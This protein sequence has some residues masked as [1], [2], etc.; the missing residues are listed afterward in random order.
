M[1]GDKEEF[2]MLP[3]SRAPESWIGRATGTAY[4]DRAGVLYV[5]VRD[6]WERLGRAT[7]FLITDGP[8]TPEEKAYLRESLGLPEEVEL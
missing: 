1:D 3:L 8:P 2:L 4:I 6:G 7:D 5:K